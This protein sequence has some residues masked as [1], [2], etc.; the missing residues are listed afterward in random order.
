MKTTQRTNLIILIAGILA[1]IMGVFV[2]VSDIRSKQ[3]NT[4]TAE[5]TVIAIEDDQQYNSNL[6]LWETVYYPVVRFSVNGVDKEYKYSQFYS[7]EKYRIGDKVLIH[8]DPN[9][10][11]K[12]TIDEDN[13][14]VIIAAWEIPVGVLLIALATFRYFHK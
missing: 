2:L 8:Y 1:V 13:R 3:T 5:A 14:S 12:F 10:P 6:D 4:Q 7:S 9:E 11:T